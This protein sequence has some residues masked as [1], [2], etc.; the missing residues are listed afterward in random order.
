[1][2]PENY[3]AFKQQFEAVVKQTIP[4]DLRSPEIQVD[5]AIFLSD[6]SPKFF[7]ILNRM[8]PFGPQNMH[9]VFMA[10]GLRDNGFGK[11]VG[12]DKSHLKLSILDGSQKT[13]YNAIGFGMGDK[14][15]LITS[16]KPFEAAFT[17]GENHWNG[18][19]SLQ[20]FLKD[21]REEA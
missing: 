20:L 10:R 7:R 12:A 1:M 2:K 14:H 5:A 11:Q 6:I 13:T 21:I 15:S 8:A 9:P 18:I 4:E 3:E 17:V 19:T 16:G